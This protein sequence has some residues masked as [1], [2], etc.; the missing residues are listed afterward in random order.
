V[1]GL[2]YVGIGVIG[3]FVTGFGNLTDTSTDALLGI[4]LINPF[5]NIVHIGIGSLWLLA[6]FVLSPAGTEGVNFAIGGIYLLA[7]VLGFLG[8][9]AMLNVGHH[10]DPDNFLHLVSGLVPLLFAGP[11]RAM[12]GEMA[13]T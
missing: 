4:F 6:G 9:L 5:H 10:A 8:Y 12:R 13:T 11:L 3:F 2:V 7:A 1:A